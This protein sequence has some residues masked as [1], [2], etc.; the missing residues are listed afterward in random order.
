[1][2]GFTIAVPL[3]RHPALDTGGAR[4]AAVLHLIKPSVLEEDVLV[5]DDH[6]G[7]QGLDERV[8]GGL[9]DI[10][11]G[12]KVPGGGR[13]SLTAGETVILLHPRLPSVGVSIWTERGCQQNESLAAG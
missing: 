4:D 5:G 13:P 7:R 10:V 8:G 3:G 9:A 6:E 1:M 12:G 2:S 11:G